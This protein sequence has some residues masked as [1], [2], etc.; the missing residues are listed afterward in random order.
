[1]KISEIQ[2]LIH[3]KGFPDAPTSV[4]L[5]ETHISWVILTD[6]FAYKI[7]KPITFSFL[8]FSTLESRHH[9]C[10]RE[11]LLNKRLAPNM[12]LGV[13]PIKEQGGRFS[14]GAAEGT[15]VDYVVYMR[16]MDHHRQMDIL[17]NKNQVTT[18]DVRKIAIQIADFH[19]RTDQ[20]FPLGDYAKS[21]HLKF[22]DLISTQ[23]FI[24]QYLGK[25]SETLIQEIIQFSS[26]F[27]KQHS[28]R[29]K[30]RAELGFIID[31]HGD[32][33]ARNIF[34]MENPIIFDCIEFDDDHRQIDVLSDIAF[35]CM[36]LDH[37]NKEDL[38][39]EFLKSYLS[40]YSCMPLAE[41][42][43]IFQYYK[44]FRANVRLKVLALAGI[45]LEN[46]G[47]LTDNQLYEIR[48]Y[49][50]LMKRYYLTMEKKYLDKIL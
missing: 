40:I 42:E 48:S 21:I 46:E 33:H 39:R 28:R 29:F 11:Y 12:Y 44:L 32:L 34:L 16:K 36:D 2:Q 35:F 14:I 8:D 25:E 22:A 15:I 13:L 3:Q 26:S 9:F 49:F 38:S 50:R 18:E 5:I 4:E 19:Q 23:A 10:Q 7:K 41:D 6:Q 30:E 20:I 43:G 1:M 37:K 47:G 24:G 17:L 27:T 45:Q 31:G